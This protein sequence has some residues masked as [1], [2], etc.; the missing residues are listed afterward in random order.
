METKRDCPFC[1]EKAVI[2]SNI[3]EKEFKKEK[4]QISEFFYKCESCGEEFTTK[5]TDILVINQ[6]YNQYREKYELPFPEELVQLREKYK[7][8]AQKMSVILGLGIN[9]YSNYEKG[10]IPSTANAKL[11]SG[12]KNPEMFSFYLSQSK[13]ILGEHAYR[14]LL[15]HIKTISPAKEDHYLLCNFNWH[16]EPDRFTGYTVP[17]PEKTSNLLLYFLSNC[18]PEFN[19]KLK[20]NKMLFYT[21]FLNY[22]TTGRSISGISYRAIPYGPVPSNYDFIFAHFIEKEEII[23]PVFHKVNHSKVNECYRPL[24]DF[25]LSVFTVEELD[26]IKK[27][28]ELFRNTPSWDLVELSHKEKAWVELNK[29]R[30]II[31][32]QD[33][34]FYLSI[35]K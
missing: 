18:N 25:D 9:T 11:I 21:D 4:F 30:G 6:V 5:E 1:D 17:S 10:E 16:S 19:D 32:Y 22:K 34:A 31:S 15:G 3:T 7:L 28:V 33:Y 35:D 23:E 26:T 29:T 12:A 24:K 14:K 13:N 2:K 27:V 8:S 20:L